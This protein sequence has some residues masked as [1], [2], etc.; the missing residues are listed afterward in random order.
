MI[1]HCLFSINPPDFILLVASTQTGEIF[2]SLTWVT[3]SYIFFGISGILEL[4]ILSETNCFFYLI[5][6]NSSYVF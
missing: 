4:L 2:N 5:L 6:G 1:N 3:F